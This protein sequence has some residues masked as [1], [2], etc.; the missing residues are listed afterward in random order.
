MY[1]LNGDD[2]DD[3][4]VIEIVDLNEFISWLRQ[5]SLNLALM[6]IGKNFFD[7]PQKYVGIWEDPDDED[8]SEDD[9]FDEIIPY[10]FVDDNDQD[11]F[12]LLSKDAQKALG[13]VTNKLIY[14]FLNEL[15]DEGVLEMCWNDET[16]DFMWRVSLK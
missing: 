16:N 2:F 9:V 4:P 8:L 6:Q 13:E 5:Q 12:Y 1:F 15:V 14:V 11:K 10:L 7:D 3:A